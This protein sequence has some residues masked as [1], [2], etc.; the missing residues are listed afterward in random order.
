VNKSWIFP[1]TKK[2][3]KG[4]WFGWKIEKEKLKEGIQIPHV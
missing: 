4:A 3:K 1:D 2:K